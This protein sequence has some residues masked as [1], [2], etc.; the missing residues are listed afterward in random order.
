MLNKK[1]IIVIAFVVLTTGC[2]GLGNKEISPTEYQ[3]AGPTAK[4][5]IT[6]PEMRDYIHV[7]FLNKRDISVNFFTDKNGCPEFESKGLGYLYTVDINKNDWDHN[8][9]VPSSGNIYGQ[10]FNTW[11]SGGNSVTCTQAF[12]VSPE[13]G[14]EYKLNIQVQ[15]TG[16]NNKCRLTLT[17]KSGGIEKS[18]KNANLD[19][20]YMV[21]ANNIS[22]NKDICSK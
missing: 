7:P 22:V 19:S 20:Q 2:A 5:N 17:D 14:A 10:V 8:I 3:P 1:N 13:Q 6:S 21:I 16:F 12:K 4:V 9:L 15:K 11:A 18:F